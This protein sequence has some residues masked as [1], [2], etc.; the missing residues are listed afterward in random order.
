MCSIASTGSSSPT[1]R[2]TSR[3]QRPPAFT[4]CSAVTSPASVMTRQSP[5]CRTSSSTRA[6]VWISAPAMRAHRAKAWVV[7]AGS[8]CPSTGS[9]SA[10]TK[11]FASISGNR[12][13]ASRGESS[14]SSM[15][16]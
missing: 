2:P 8:R 1:I 4:T 3:A 12:S 6:W 9:K 16:R 7:P 14:A 11:A 10:P 13:A 5:S 15:P